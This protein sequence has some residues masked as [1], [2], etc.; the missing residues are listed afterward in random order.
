GQLAETPALLAQL[1]IV[2]SVKNVETLRLTKAGPQPHLAAS[3][4]PIKNSFGKTIGASMIARDIDD[5]K[6]HEQERERLISDLQTA[7]AQVKMLSGLL[8][9]C[10]SCKKIRD[11]Q[12]YWNQ[13]EVYVMAHSRPGLTH[14]IC[15]E[16]ANLQ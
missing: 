7:L 8:P 11:D 9:I 10:A 12:G 6:R 13:V 5:R 2:H 1:K 3:V 15:P 4:S 16:R 14:R